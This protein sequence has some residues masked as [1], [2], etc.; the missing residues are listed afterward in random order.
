MRAVDGSGLDFALT[1]D[2][3]ALRQTI[4]EFAESEVAKAAEEHDDAGTV[5]TELFPQ[6]AELGLW[7]I[8]IPEEFGGAGLGYVE[9]VTILQELARVDPSTALTVAAHNSLG[10]G[11]LNQHGNDEQRRRWL[12]DLAAG[13]KLAAWALTEPSSGSD[14]AGLKTV[15]RKDGDEWVLD[16]LKNFITNPNVGEFAIVLA[17]TDE[18][19]PQHGVTAFAVD[20]DGETCR[21]GKKENKLGMRTSDTAE[22]VLSG[23][24]VGAD[25]VVGELNHGFVDALKV[26]DGGRISIAALSL[27]LHLGCLDQSR[28]Y[29]KERVAFGKTIAS[30]QAIQWMLADMEMTYEAAAALTYRAALLKDQGQSVNLESSMAKLYA[31]DACCVAA[32]RGVQLHGGYGFIKDYPIERF[33]RD[34]KLCTIGEGTSEVQRIVIA[35]QLLS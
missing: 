9:Y 35:R 15:A 6:I 12:P 16:G 22:L 30:F 33:Y 28:K 32:E 34:C 21:A 4:R 24:R 11:H 31:S 18:A 5:P 3:E 1:E 19:N 13:N 8:L 2:Q 10:S 23:C 29:A 20:I 17:L 26:L 7:G 25:R 14:A 27:G